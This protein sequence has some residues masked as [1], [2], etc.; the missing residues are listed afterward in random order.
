[1]NCSAVPSSRSVWRRGISLALVALVLTVPTS[2]GRLRV[3]SSAAA[4]NPVGSWPTYHHDLSRSGSDPTVAPFSSVQSQWVSATL[5]G[6]VYAQPLVVGSTVIVATEGDSLYALDARTGSVL[7][8]TNV[9]TPVPGGSLPC[10]N[11]DPVG[12]TGTAAIDTTTN[13]IYA[14]A[15]VSQPSPQYILA[16]LDLATGNLRFSRAINP[17]GLDPLVTGQRGAL[18]LSQGR[19]YIPFGGRFGDCGDYHGWVVGASATD[20]TLPL[21]V[22]QVPTGRGGGAWAPSGVAV[23]GAGNVFVS[24]GNSFTTTAFDHG[25]SV[26]R[27]SPSLIEQDFFAPT[28]WADLNATD[29]DLG[30]VGPALLAGG[31]VFQIGKD[32]IAY[33]LQAN[34]LGHIGGQTFS[35]PVCAE[36]FGGVAYLGPYVYVPCTDGLVALQL[37]GPSFAV[38]WRGP[39]FFAGPP[40]VAGGAVWTISRGGTLYALDPGTGQARFQNALGG[41]NNFASPAAASGSIFAPAGSHLAAF[42]LV[43]TSGQ[44]QPL[45]PLRILDTRSGVGGFGTV[46]GGQTIDVPVAGQGGVP[47]MTSVTPPSA[48]V[49]NVTVTNPTLPGYVTVYPTGLGRPLASNLNFVAGQT[50]PNLV[51]VALGAGGKVSVF[52]L[53]GRTDVIFDVAGW[54]S[55]QGTITGTAG[56]FRSLVPTRLLDTRSGFGGSTTMSA[57]QTITLQ[58]AGNGGVPGTGAAAVVLNVTAAKATTTGYLTVFPT[59]AAQPVASNLNFVAGQTVPNRVMVKLGSAG[60]VSIFNFAG[61]TDV[62]VDVGGWFTDGSDSTAAGGQFTG[63][64]PLRLLD[65]RNGTGG[66]ST[67]VAGG[68]ALLVQAAG[69]GGVPA[70]SAAV[71]PRAVV[72]NVTVTNTTAPSFLTV[73]PSDATRPT[74]SDLNW[75]PGQ[76]VPNLV[77]VK[78]GADGKVAIFNAAGSTDVIADVVGWYS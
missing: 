74:A 61:S 28:N 77:V 31:L 20:A 40:I 23:D 35:A 8:R 24:T 62:V 70:T 14:V 37:T 73:Y 39:A 18:A 16:A 26:I 63:L 19:V 46:T 17:A 44:Y 67:P 33:L 51:E 41:V 42:S 57:G 53:Q 2:P 49:L 66:A 30:S 13:V 11:I 5:D 38:V 75:T 43:A 54:V 4:F 72:L 32:G 64:S 25:E 71:P 59:G 45:A 52:N 3:T 34:S 55:T 9:G 60:Q 12:I 65:T 15:M 76:T 29:T 69:Q 1:M 56:L 27:L 22:Y 48:A 58:V 6:R 10:G 50:V 21:L 68:S 7:W 36:A 47:A 78:L